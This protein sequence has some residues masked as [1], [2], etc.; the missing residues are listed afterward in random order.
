MSDDSVGFWDWPGISVPKSSYI[1]PKLDDF[2]KAYLALKTAGGH[3]PSTV[4]SAYQAALNAGHAI[5]ANLDAGHTVSSDDFNNFFDLAAAFSSRL[6]ASVGAP[7][8]AAAASG[9]AKPDDHVLQSPVHLPS[10]ADAE[11]AIAAA[12]PS[13]STIAIVGGVGLFAWWILSGMGSSSRRA[14]A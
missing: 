7:I 6:P 13:W 4:W 2:E 10:L 5:E 12:V 14:R 1:Y 9:S 8:A 11:A 3:V